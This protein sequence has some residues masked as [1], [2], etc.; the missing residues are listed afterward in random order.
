MFKLQA[1]FRDKKL[2]AKLLFARGE[3]YYYEIMLKIHRR[4]YSCITRY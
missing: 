4:I 3:K 2:R 1:H